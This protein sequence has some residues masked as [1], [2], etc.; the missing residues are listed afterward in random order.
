MPPRSTRGML[1]LAL[2]IAAAVLALPTHAADVKTITACVGG[3]H[4]SDTL[5]AL[6]DDKRRWK[7]RLHGIEAPDLGELPGQAAKRAW[8]DLVFSKQETLHTICTDRYGHTL[9]HVSVGNIKEAA[10]MVATGHAWRCK[11]Y[12]YEAAL[13]AWDRNAS[14]AGRGL[15]R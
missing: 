9:A 5:T 13:E 12:D 10:H 4:A 8:P 14:V 15:R 1:R 3:V 11:R 6:A 2:T 7:V